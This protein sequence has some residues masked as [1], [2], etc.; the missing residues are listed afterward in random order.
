MSKRVII[1]PDSFKGSLSSKT[2]ASTI[3][4]ALCEHGDYEIV[5]IPIADGGEGTASC[6]LSFL[7][8]STKTIKV[9]SPEDKLID[10]N[11]VITQKNVAVIEIAESSG[12]T[13]QEQLNPLLSNT[14]GFGELISDALNEG[15]REFILCL[16]GSASTDCGL[17]MAEALGAKFFDKNGERVRPSGRTLLDIMSVDTSEMDERLPECSFT[18]MS[19]VE[20]PLFGPLGAAQAFAPQKGASH[21]QVFFLE[22]GLKHISDVLRGVGFKD[23]MLVRGAGAAGGA[24]YGCTAFL[25][26]KL[27]SGMTVLL[28]LCRF[29]DK[30]KTAD[31]V[32]TGEGKFDE[33]SLMGKV[34]GRIYERSLSKPMIVFCEK[35][36]FSKDQLEKKNISVVEI[37]TDIPLEESINNAESLLYSKACEFF[38]SN[39]M[40]L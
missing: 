31:F 29:D 23:A 28:E 19:D 35:C 27:E 37:A 30:I 2:V 32:I 15:I 3:E 13:K 14:F 24:G 34:V 7:H 16:G 39:E 18:V 12:I 20:N 8:G 21:E 26:A 25:N 38:A 4:R 11:Y 22:A 33:Q 36:D 6:L 5:C 1:I 17:G 10:A 40:F 9:H